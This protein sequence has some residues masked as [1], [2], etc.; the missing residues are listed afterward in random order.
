MV[1]Q[2]CLFFLEVLST[3]ATKYKSSPGALPNLDTSLFRNIFEKTATQ[4][5]RPVEVEQ[6]LPALGLKVLDVLGFVEDQIPPG[7]ASER[8]VILQYQLV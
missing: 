2:C 4:L 1:L 5:Y 6:T 7:F 8:L 3:S